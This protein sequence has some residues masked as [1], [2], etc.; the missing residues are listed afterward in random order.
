[1]SPPGDV[2]GIDLT[3]HEFELFRNILEAETGIVLKESKRQLLKNRL[4]PLLVASGKQRFLQLLEGLES[5]TER[6][7]VLATIIDAITTNL[8]QF[9]REPEQLEL[10]ERRFLPWVVDLLEEDRAK[11]ITIWSGG[12]STGQEVYSV[13]MLIRELVPHRFQKRFRVL[14]TDIDTSA[15]A[16]ARRGRYHEE[17]LTGLSMERRI[18][19]LRA[20]GDGYYEATDRLMELCRFSPRNLVNPDQWGPGGYHAIFCRNV[21]IYFQQ[22][23]RER[24]LEEF[25]ARLVKG[26]FLFLGHSEGIQSRVHDFEYV[27]PSTYRRREG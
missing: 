7:V 21:L 15:L 25:H 11:Q 26:G 20:T 4:R 17:E 3:D 24:L 14:G 8:T 19:H 12:C 23:R 5:A 27:A 16:R 10:F 9:F 2:F 6:F 18:Q 13:A 1:M 22:S